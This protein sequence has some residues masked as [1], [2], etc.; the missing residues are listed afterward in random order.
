M[1]VVEINSKCDI[2]CLIIQICKCQTLFFND[3]T[4]KVNSLLA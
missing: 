3:G 1:W 2:L 4:F